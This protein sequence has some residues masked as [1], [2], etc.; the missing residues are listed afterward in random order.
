MIDWC[1]DHAPTTAAALRGPVDEQFLADAQ[2]ATTTIWPDQLLAWLR[3]GDGAD[4]LPEASVLP[5]FFIPLG[6]GEIVGD[7][8]MLRQIAGQVASPFD[9]ATVEAQPAG[10][11]ASVFLRSWVP[12]A[13]DSGGDF[14]FVDLRAGPRHGC[15]S[16]WV[17]GEGFLRE[18][19]WDDL[20][21]MLAAVAEG[22]RGGRWVAPDDVDD[23]REPVVIDGTLRWDYGPGWEVVRAAT[24]PVPTP[25]ELRDHFLL[26]SGVGRTDGEI[27]VQLGVPRHVVAELRD[28]FPR[29]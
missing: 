17:K 3:T 23:V 22:L 25:E 5:P 29:P 21:A 1:R 10:S 11:P 12:V 16:Q 9:Q 13:A 2:L 14:Y 6:V 8:R 24:R 19:L 26:L 15:V 20:A 4:P 28:R 7:W 27:A 18:P